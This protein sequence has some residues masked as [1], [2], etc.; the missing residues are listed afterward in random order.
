MSQQQPR[1]RR[2][3]FAGQCI[4]LQG[5]ATA[6]SGGGM[7]GVDAMRS[8]TLFSQ[9][10]ALEQSCHPSPSL[11]YVVA[12]PTVAGCSLGGHAAHLQPLVCTNC[13]GVRGW[14]QAH[15]TAPTQTKCHLLNVLAAQF[16]KPIPSQK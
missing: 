7:Q 9:Q 10:S 4:P 5:T 16:E 13:V 2:M 8:G 3:A 12:L 15:V 1:C 14:A 11:Y 6:R